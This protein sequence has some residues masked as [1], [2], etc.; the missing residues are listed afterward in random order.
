MTDDEP[1]SAN[2]AL[3]AR[4]GGTGRRRVDGLAQRRMD[5][6]ESQAVPMLGRDPR[7]RPAPLTA[8]QRILDRFLVG[9]LSIIAITS[10]AGIVTAYWLEAA[11]T[12]ATVEQ[13]RVIRDQRYL[14]G[15]TAATA[16]GREME[17][18]CAAV[19]VLGAQDA[20]PGGAYW[21][22]RKRCEGFE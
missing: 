19:P 3:A 18:M 7:D 9:G 22:V 12:T 8:A 5:V 17:F 4:S 2:R 10:L 14:Q 13:E 1:A 21:A 15:L 6:L 20:K 16:S 11:K